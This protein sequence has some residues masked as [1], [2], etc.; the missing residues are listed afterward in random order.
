MNMDLTRRIQHWAFSQHGK[1]G[2]VILLMVALLLFPA[3]P[4]FSQTDVTGSF[5]VERGRPYYDYAHQQTY[6]TL[7]LANTSAQSFQNAIRLTIDSITSP[8][9]TV[10]SP[11][12]LT[13]DGKPYVNLPLPRHDFDGNGTVDA[14]DLEI[15]AADFGRTD[16]DQ[17]AVCEGDFTRDGDVDGA[18]YYAS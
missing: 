2:C 8:Q 10:R 18:K 6:T 16:C 14:A 3:T 11:S 5:K 7:S 12:C 9:V 4:V 1:T 17:E 13:N 15:M